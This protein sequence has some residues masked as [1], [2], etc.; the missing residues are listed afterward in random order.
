MKDN[1]IANNKSGL[2]KA[3][4]V[5]VCGLALVVSLSGCDSLIK[6]GQPENATDKVN[7][8]TSEFSQTD[9]CIIEVQ[10]YGT[11]TVGL[12][13][14]AA[15]ITV[16]NFKKLVNE[17]FYNGLTFHRIISG[18]MIQGGDPKGDGTGDSSETIKG[19]FTSNGVN[20]YLK[21]TRGAISMA[22]SSANDSASCQFFIVH[23][24]SST[25]TRSLDGKY[26]CFGYV[27]S[28]M[29]VVDAICA[30]VKPTDDNGT[31]EKAN[32]PVI[33]SIKML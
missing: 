12:D 32:Q 18:F 6:F 15:P 22:R 11:I 1:V 17:G 33:T 25:N 24:T 21:H 14:N 29:E 23:E 3:I 20:N 13:A 26:A 28:G 16:A 8:S 10:N 4:L 30:N 19:E 27:T 7:S 2:L 9:A 31:V 5:C